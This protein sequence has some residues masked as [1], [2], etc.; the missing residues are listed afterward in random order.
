MAVKIQVS[1]PVAFFREDE[2]F[3][4]H[5]PVLDVSTSG[6]T[7]KEAQKRFTEA[8]EIFFEELHEKGT[9]NEVLASLGWKQ[10]GREWMPPVMVSQEM[11]KV[12]LVLAN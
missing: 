10:V 4:A 3:I 12:N 1:V 2:V 7:Y 8:V 5:S 6:K 11:N 9:L